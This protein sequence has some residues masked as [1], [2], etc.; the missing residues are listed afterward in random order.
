MELNR[1]EMITICN[2]ESEAI[3]LIKYTG[4]DEYYL[5]WLV[6]YTPNSSFLA[7][8]KEA[9]KVLRGKYI[10]RFDVV[11]SSADFYKIKN[12]NG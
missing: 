10:N 7:R 2:C 5:Q 3:R 12:F 11:L 9:F 1:K 4:E 8:C 6:S